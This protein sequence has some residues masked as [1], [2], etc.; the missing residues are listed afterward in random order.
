[1]DILIS[2]LLLKSI[3]NFGKWSNRKLCKY[4]YLRNFK[5]D[6]FPKSKIGRFEMIMSIFQFY[7]FLTGCGQ[8]EMYG[9]TKC[10]RNG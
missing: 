1:M 9:E 3:F 7:F 10:H 2:N 6:H 5:F 8:Y 4:T